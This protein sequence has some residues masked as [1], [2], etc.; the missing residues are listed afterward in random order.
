MNSNLDTARESVSSENQS[1]YRSIFKATSLFGGVQVYQILISVIKSKFVAVLLG[2]LGVG[3]MGLYQSAIQLIQ[4]ITSLGLSSS[5]VRDVS[6]ANG[7]G[8]IN[9]INKIITVLKKLVWFT[10]LFGLLVTAVLSPILSKATFGNY[11][12]TV[13]FI[14]LSIVLLLDQIAAGQRVVLQGMRRLQDLA[15]STAIGSTIGLIISVPLY[16]LMGIKGIVPTLI[17]NSVTML[18]LT[19]FYSNKIK[20]NK[21]KL[22]S[23]T[24]LIDG[25]GMLRM[26]LSMSLS[27]ILVY[28]TSYVLMWFIRSSSGAEAAG[29]YT[30]GFTIINTYVGMIFTAIGTDYY[31]RLAAVNKDNKKCRDIINQQGEIA[32]LIM[33]PLLLICIVFMP[34]ALKILYSNQFILANDYVMY[35]SLG[36]MFKL[37]SW[38]IAFQFIAKGNSKLFIINEIIANTYSLIFNI[39]GYQLLGLKGLGISFTLNFFIYFIQVFYV[40]KKNYHYSFSRKYSIIFTY[41]VL[42]VIISILFA[43]ID[44]IYLYYTLGCVTIFISSLYSIKQLDNRMGIIKMVKLFFK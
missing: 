4:S 9:K 32:S 42:L 41:Q 30:A 12:Y 16:Y 11:D 33:T 35:A 2:P 26:G 40:A 36:M 27:S 8:D 28:G 18:L 19:W 17:L 3:I 37:G 7:T 38:L 15:K 13:P 6:E 1:S 10:G 24:V 44:N 14:C 39:I 29:L 34:I 22:S 20:T 21:V 25:A 23:K 31:P 43:S 5:A